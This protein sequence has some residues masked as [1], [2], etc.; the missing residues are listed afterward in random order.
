MNGNIRFVVILLICCS[1]L[2]AQGPSAGS[3]NKNFAAVV[4][5]VAVVGTAWAMGGLVGCIPCAVGGGLLALGA[6][7]M[8]YW[9]L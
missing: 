4:N 7:A 1:L 9:L 6:G 3:Q 2:M 8:R 5:T